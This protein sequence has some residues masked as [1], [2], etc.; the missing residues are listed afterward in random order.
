MSPRYTN[1]MIDSVL[2]NRGLSLLQCSTYDVSATQRV[3]YSVH[4]AA[5][6]P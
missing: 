6:R 3:S 4:A 1:V 2:S 5:A